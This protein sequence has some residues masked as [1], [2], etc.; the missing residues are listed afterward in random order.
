MPQGLEDWKD[1]TVVHRNRE[2]GHVALGVY[3]DE[4]TALTGA[5][6]PY[7]VSLDGTWKFQIYDTPDAVPAGFEK[8]DYDDANWYDITVPGNWQLQGHDRPIYTNVQYPHPINPDFAPMLRK[9]YEKSDWNHILSIR[10]P[11]EAMAI[12]LEPPAHNPTG[13]YRTRF[14]VPEAWAGRPVFLRFE[15]VDS[16][17]HLWVNGQPVGYST[18]SRLPAEF[19]ISQYVSPGENVLAMEVYRWPVSSYIEDQDYWRLS[20][21]YRSV[22]LWSAPPVMLWDYTVRTGLDQDYRHAML[23][24][25]ATIRAAGGGATGYRLEGQLLDAQDNALFDAPLVSA[26]VDG[27]AALAGPVANPHK[28]SDEQP[29]LYTLVLTLRD[30]NGEVVQVETARVGFRVVEIRNGQ[31]MVNGRPIRVKGVNRHEHHPDTGHTVSVESMLADIELMKQANI[32]AVRTCHYPDDPRW[33]DLCD[34]YG[35]FVLDEANI[36]SHG[37]WDRTSRDPDWQEMYVS[38]CANM[39][40]R[41]KN[42]PCVIGWSMG[43]ESGFGQ[44]FTA[45]SAW[46]RAHDPTRPIHYHPAE[47]DPAIDIIAP[48][49][50]TVDRLVELAQDPNDTRPIIMCEYAHA[51]GNSPGG[52]K[53]YWEA[54]ER[55]PRLQGGFVWDWV[56]QGLRRVADDGTE[57]FA[58]GGDYGD[59]PNDGNFCCN[60]VITP[61]RE[62]HPGLLEMKKVQE[63]VWVEAVDLANGK[64]RVTNRYAFSTL[65]GLNI[66]WSVEEDG[67]TIEAGSL[68]R[69]NT[70]PGASDLVTVPYT[71][72]TAQPGADYRLTLRF[73]LADPAAWAQRGHEVAWA[74]YALPVSAA[75]PALRRED[76]PAVSVAETGNAITVNGQNFALRFDKATGRLAEWKHGGQAVVNSGPALNLYRAPTDNDVPRMAGLWQ[77]VGLDSLVEQVTSVSARQVAPQ[78]VEVTVNTTAAAPGKEPVADASYVY[79]IYGSGDVTLEQAVHL[80]SQTDAHRPQTLAARRRAAGR[81]AAH[82]AHRRD[83]GAARGLRTIPLVW[84]WPA[85]DLL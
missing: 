59:D 25:G 64:F 24:V 85:R 71:Q 34:E 43:N 2:D 14:T 46:I 40:K 53:E 11:E 1:P 21:V 79:S 61:D 63:P 84:P 74:Q 80:A 42:H 37:V 8:P 78:L 27:S 36:E 66:A 12:P 30:P 15:A 7:R 55:Y 18:D 5:T 35:L 51:M 45:A 73:T 10:I 44:N 22:A 57:W 9:M 16:A 62:P 82:A 56:D 52:L 19:D 6:S 28:W 26:V 3:P 49:Y 76:M 38:R 41:D 54:V 39:V 81:P 29:Y 23:T 83:A 4:A 47:D 65:A 70:A 33:Y 68:P 60:G 77:G 67:A 58:Y 50:P 20:G 48:M 31:L 69:L 75:A 17:F 32:N 13:L 72:P